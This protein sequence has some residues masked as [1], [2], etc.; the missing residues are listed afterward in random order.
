PR[1]L[2]EAIRTAVED[3]GLSRRL[4]P[5]VSVIVDGGGRIGMDA[6]LADVRLTAVR[7]EQETYWHLAVGGTATTAQPVGPL[8]EAE[9]CEATVATL[10]AIA[11]LG[12]EGRGKNINAG[13]TPTPNPSPQG[14]GEAAAPLSPSP[15]WGGV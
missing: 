12:H 2:A 14:R 8:A 9:A 7:R 4:G 15:L 10:E 1:P 13:H 6:L 5:K 3:A 11:A